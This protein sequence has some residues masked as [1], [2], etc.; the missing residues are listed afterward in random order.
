MT[1]KIT[2][3]FELSRKRYKL[4]TQ[5]IAALQNVDTLA[6]L[7]YTRYIALISDYEQEM[8][9][10]Y[11]GATLGEVSEGL[12]DQQIKWEKHK[13][14]YVAVVESKSWP[15]TVVFKS[16]LSLGEIRKRHAEAAE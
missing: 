16:L 6:E 4:M 3:T 7:D 14:Y 10:K 15:L 12:V 8:V 13:S 2:E 5:I 1:D 11:T 9:F